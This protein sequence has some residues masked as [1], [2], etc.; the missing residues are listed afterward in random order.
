M[1]SASQILSFVISTIDAICSL[2]DLSISN[3]EVAEE[4]AK[5][6]YDRMVT[7]CA[8]EI[9]EDK[10][11]ENDS[12]VSSLDITPLWGEEHDGGADPTE[13]PG[14]DATSQGFMPGAALR[15]R[16]TD[17]TDS[18]QEVKD[19]VAKHFPALV[20]WPDIAPAPAMAGEYSKWHR[21]NNEYQF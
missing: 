21:H 15:L 9:L 7:K 6:E 10:E 14:E 17:T 16:T 18:L 1:G 4:Y 13:G 5:L 19:E 12:Q 11:T 3:Y 8:W 2:E 20:T